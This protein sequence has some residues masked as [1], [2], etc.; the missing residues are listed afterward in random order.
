[1]VVQKSSNNINGCDAI[2]P[3]K[4]PS[5]NPANP[6]VCR[7]CGTPLGRTGKCPALCEPVPAPPPKYE[8]DP[9]I[10]RSHTTRLLSGGLH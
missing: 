6:R 4:H 1:M 2:K 5:K 3:E 8:G 10:G 7:T 9:I